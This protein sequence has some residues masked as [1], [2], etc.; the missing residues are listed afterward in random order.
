M[1]N[2]IYLLDMN[3]LEES[4]KQLSDTSLKFMGLYIARLFLS[5][6]RHE[7]AWNLSQTDYQAF[8]QS[9]PYGYLQ[10]SGK[11]VDKV[12]SEGAEVTRMKLTFLQRYLKEIC[13]EYEYRFGEKHPVAFA[14]EVKTFFLPMEIP[15]KNLKDFIEKVSFTKNQRKAYFRNAKMIYT[16]RE[17]PT[18]IIE[19][20]NV[21]TDWNE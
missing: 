19:R 21:E 4:S 5:A 20:A 6:Y 9:I 17:R 18:W 11:Y 1:L 7:A 10:L 15:I 13:K 16:K 3:S 2:R 8:L 12:L 14:V